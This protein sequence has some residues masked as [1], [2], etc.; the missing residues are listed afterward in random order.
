MNKANLWQIGVL[1]LLVVVLLFFVG[2][3]EGYHMD[4]VL[5]Y[6]LANSEYNPFIITNKPVG[7][8]AQFMSDEIQGDTL[9]QT[10][11]NLWRTAM[12]VVRNGSGSKLMQSKA[13]EYPEAVWFSRQQFVDYMTVNESDG[14]NPLSAYLGAQADT[15]PPLYYMALHTACALVPGSASPVIAGCLNILLLLGTCVLM[16]KLFGYLEQ[17]GIFSK[18]W[19]LLLG[20]AAS[21]LYGLSAGGISTVLLARMYGLTTLFAVWSFYLHVKLCFEGGL[22]KRYIALAVITAAGFLSQYFFVFY[23]I[24]LALVTVVLLAVSQRRKEIWRYVATMVGAAASGVGC[25]P[26]CIPDLF[27]STMGNSVTGGFAFSLDRFSQTVSAMAGV[28]LD[29]FFGKRILGYVLLTLMVV[30]VVLLKLRNRATEQKIRFETA[31]LPEGEIQPAEREEHVVKE[32]ATFAWL[33]FAPVILAFLL[34][35]NM[36]IY[37]MPRYLMPLFP[38]VAM[39]MALW[40]QRFFGVCQG[41]LRYLIFVPVILFCAY[42]CATYSGAGLYKGYEKQVELAKE[43]QDHSCICFTDFVRYYENV[44]EFMEYDRTLITYLYDFEIRQDK[45]ELDALQEVIVLRKSEVDEAR[46]FQA[47]QD[48]GFVLEE[49]LLDA[50]D[51]PWGDSIYLWKRN[52]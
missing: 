47:M 43:Y 10:A 49:K 50:V 13:V 32:R 34:I 46:M 25:F 37:W 24:P 39:W 2:Q 30:T 52:N 35:A 51:S 27:S 29:G 4:E 48:N 18:N 12:D 26:F 45:T 11:G 15:H 33:L 3:K 16:M 38:F 31:K 7:R 40:L 17:K 41:K 36:T 8:L 23:C 5:S 1:L 6:Q 44:P 28:G 20:M 19:G 22:R 21:L 9:W 42:Q 14:F